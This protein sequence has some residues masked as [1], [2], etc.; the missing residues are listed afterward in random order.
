MD[1]RDPCKT[2]DGKR[3]FFYYT[4]AEARKAAKR[5]AKKGNKRPGTEQL[6]PMHYRCPDCG[7]YHVGNSIYDQ[8][9]V[10]LKSA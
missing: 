5:T 9:R 4:A 6:R 3:K 10:R 2:A 8:R 7:L 1:R